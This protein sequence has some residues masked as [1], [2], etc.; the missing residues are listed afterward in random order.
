MGTQQGGA[1]SLSMTPGGLARLGGRWPLR[2][3]SR[4]PG[5]WDTNTLS[6][7]THGGLAPLGRV[8]RPAVASVLK[9]E[10]FTFTRHRL[11]SAP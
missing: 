9:R 1:E 4:R 8:R 6:G 7:A 11:F 2:A 5:P 10:L 3:G